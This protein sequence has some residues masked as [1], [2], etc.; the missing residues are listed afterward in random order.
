MS[1]KVPFAETELIKDMHK[2]SSC[3]AW[4]SFSELWVTWTAF[5]GCP[6]NDQTRHQGVH[7]E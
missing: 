6:V 2:W 1:K 5:I 4:G 7:L 3:H